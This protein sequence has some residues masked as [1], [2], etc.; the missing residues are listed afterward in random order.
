MLLRLVVVHT[1][2]SEGSDSPNPLLQLMSV[3][4]PQPMSDTPYHK[5][6]RDAGL[7]VH[8]HSLRPCLGLKVGVGRSHGRPRV[9]FASSPRLLCAPSR[10]AFSRPRRPPKASVSF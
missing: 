2:L 4:F 10:R 8:V 7:L 3:G 9:V 6:P 1:S 5:Q